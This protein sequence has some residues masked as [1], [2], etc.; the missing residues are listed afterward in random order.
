MS[1]PAAFWDSSALIP[2]CVLQAQT[3]RARALYKNL[4]IVV[5]WATPVEIISGLTRLERMGDIGRDQLLIARKRARELADIWASLSPSSITLT[6]A[7]S[8]LEAHPL[9]AADA[10]QL[11][12]ALEACEQEPHG[13]VFVTADQRLAQAA[14]QIGFSVEFI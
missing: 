11:A 7:C 8:L 12:A 5:W 14:R 1:L 9:R 2:L 3:A 4:G 13:Y 10:L 6:Q